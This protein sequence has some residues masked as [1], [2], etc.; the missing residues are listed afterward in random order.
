MQKDI[1]NLHSENV[2]LL[3]KLETE[4]T[5]NEVLSEEYASRSKYLIKFINEQKFRGKLHVLAKHQG[6][7]S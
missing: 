2:I 4:K 7:A 6:S 5:K 3:E 1:N